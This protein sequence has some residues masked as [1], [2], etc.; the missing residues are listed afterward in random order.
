M[1]VFKVLNM[2]RST[3]RR[4][5]SCLAF[6]LIEDLGVVTTRAGCARVLAIDVPAH[7]ARLMTTTA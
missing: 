5:D 7:V 3:A 4:L 2:A 1:R 6:I